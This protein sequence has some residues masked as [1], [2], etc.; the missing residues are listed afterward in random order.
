[1][2]ANYS[3]ASSFLTPNPSRKHPQNCSRGLSSKVSIYTNE[4]NFVKPTLKFYLLI[5][6]KMFLLEPTPNSLKINEII[7]RLKNKYTQGH[8]GGLGIVVA[9]E[10][11]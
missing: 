3:N 5:Y 11:S 9:Y 2:Q 1:M 4:I 10:S 6:L 8:I 7:I